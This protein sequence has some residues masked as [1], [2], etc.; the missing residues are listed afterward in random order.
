MEKEFEFPKTVYPLVCA[1]RLKPR[2]IVIDPDVERG[3]TT[4]AACNPNPN[5]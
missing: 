1:D 3:A 5:P 2:T 4:P